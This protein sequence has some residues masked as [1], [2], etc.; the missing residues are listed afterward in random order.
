MSSP[1]KIQNS[2]LSLE[3]TDNR[4]LQVR[5]REQDEAVELNWPAVC[6]SFDGKTVR[7]TRPVGEPSVKGNALSQSFERDG[8]RFDIRLTLS[9]SCWF[10]KRVAVSSRL[11][12]PTPDFVEVDRQTLAADELRSCGYRATGAAGKAGS[13][14]EGAGV[15]PGCGYP[16][17]GKRLFTGLEHPA[18]FNHVSRRGRKATFWLRHHPV[19]EDGRLQVID[20]VFGWGDD[21]RDAFDDYLDT[22]RLPVLKGPL[23]SFCTFWSDPYL[24][25]LEYEASYEAYRAFIQ[26]FVHH[27]LVPD[28]FTLD[29]GWYDRK[30]I[31]QAKDEVAGDAGLIRLRKLAESAGSGLSLWISH[32]GPIGMDPDHMKRLGY[33][34]GGGNSATYSGDGYVVLLDQSFERVLGD[35]FCELAAKVG[36]KHF[37]MDWD[38]DGATNSRF[39]EHYPTPHH[40][41]QATNNAYI[42][43]ARRLRE[44]D[45]AFANRH[46]WVA[47]PWWLAEST[48]I[49]LPDG[50]DCEYAALPSKTQRDGA[51][52]HRDLMYY[53]V[54][55]RD[56]TAV[57]LDCFD[58]HEFPD[59]PRNPFCEAPGSWANNVWFSFL[60]GT[61]YITCKLFPESLEDWQ[62]EG[63]KRV[64]EFCRTYAKHIYTSRGRMVL[65][66]P[67][68]GE[69]YG[70]LH[71]GRGESWLALRN[72]LP[73]PQTL[74]LHL[75]DLGIEDASCATQFYPHF[76]SLPPNGD[77]SFLAH[78][79]KILVLSQRR[80]ALP[81]AQPHQVERDAGQYLYR[82]TSSEEVT[83]DVQPM[84]D[85]LQ[86][87][88][89][90]QCVSSGQD[91]VAGGRRYHWFLATPCRMRNAEVQL[92]AKGPEVR[93]LRLR[94]FVSR[95]EGS[96]GG[97]AAP[98]TT[99]APG[100]PGHGER[101]NGGAA[102]AADEVYYAISV[103][104]GGRF[105]LSLTVEGAPSKGR[106]TGAWL[107]GYEAP[108]RNAV[109]RKSG[110]ARFR[111]CLPYQHP[112]G[113]GQA[114]QLPL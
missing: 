14:E 71:P 101:K 94:A 50:G 30:S 26:A 36:V 86:R 6:V 31:F 66:H 38:N 61:T 21:G 37:K 56:G 43:I 89:G 20:Q 28:I 81:Y 62:V 7:P 92:R 112:L 80:I 109:V 49:S 103:P 84:A 100:V 79:V 70:F 69:I 77:V 55:Q 18:A 83:R 65:G 23:V 73:V 105:S 12:L 41:R 47:S 25:D 88:G 67:G 107:A 59:A 108:S 10:R 29:A 72:P 22:I 48:H 82:V 102:C 15:M 106:L 1:M 2:C 16:L 19:W 64:M 42:R 111:K 93:D 110:P 98:V 45:P 35:R 75:R 63:L 113:F 44:I 3:I 11:E 99:I 40:V 54:L 58:N 60:R 85:P 114:L 17:I 27:G 87:V 97:Y 4:R 51:M 52:T 5:H 95:Y 33:E 91:K 90:L 9:R 46:G 68:R 13:A 74:H 78:E 57:H 39:S 53:N 34:I 104:D 32:N 96:H 24:G 76:E 8:L